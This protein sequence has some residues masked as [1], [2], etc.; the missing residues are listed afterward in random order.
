MRSFRN[1]FF[2]VM[3]LS[4]YASFL[5]ICFAFFPLQVHVLPREILGKSTFEFAVTLMSWF[6]LWAVDKILV[7]L[8]T[9]ILGN[10]D[11]YGVKRPEMGPLEL[12]NSEGKTPVLDLG[13]LGKI[14]SGRIQVVPGIKRFCRGRVELVNGEAL[15]IDS[16]ILATGYR[17]N[18]PSWLKVTDKESF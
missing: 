10:T 14:R 6:P 15:E 5:L 9:L 17:S 11:K 8:A 4:T 12:K 13:T 2:L 18:V 1:V 7:T 16:V 3:N